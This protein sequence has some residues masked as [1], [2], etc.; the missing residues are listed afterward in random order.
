MSLHLE[1]RGG[2]GSEVCDIVSIDEGEEGVSMTHSKQVIRSRR[3]GEAVPS[4]TEA[5]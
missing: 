3:L 1:P 5:Q 2:G 4:C